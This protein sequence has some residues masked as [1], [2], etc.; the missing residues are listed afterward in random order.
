MEYPSRSSAADDQ[1]KPSPAQNLGIGRPI[2]NL[3]R[4]PKYHLTVLPCGNPLIPCDAP[5]SSRV[6]DG[7]EQGTGT[8]ACWP[9]GER[10]PHVDGG[11]KKY[12]TLVRAQHITCN[13]GL[14][15]Y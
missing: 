14:S 1:R 12:G 5:K 7:P 15:P 6:I 11:T 13:V 9:P 8:L 3:L 2:D 4:G 10:L